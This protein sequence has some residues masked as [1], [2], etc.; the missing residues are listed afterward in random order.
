VNEP[1]RD[2]RPATGFV[3]AIHL[4][5]V[6]V[7]DGSQRIAASPILDTRR[8]LQLLGHENGHFLPVSFIR[9]DKCNCLLLDVVAV[10]LTKHWGQGCFGLTRIIIGARYIIFA[11][12]RLLFRVS[13]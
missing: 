7:A 5:P 4:F 1:A 10:S 13:I 12:G 11:Q 2:S 9:K 6:L 8:R 3:D